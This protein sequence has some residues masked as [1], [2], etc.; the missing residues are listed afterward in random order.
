MLDKVEKVI[1]NDYGLLNYFDKKKC[2]IGSGLNVYN[3]YSV[4]HYG[5]PII[6]SHEMTRKQ[7][8]HLK[9]DHN[10]L[11]VPIYGKKELMVSEYCPISN[12]YFDEQKKHCQL[13]KKSQYQLMDRKGELLD[14][15]MDEYCRMHLLNAHTQL[16][17]KY[18]DIDA[19]TLLIQFTN[20]EPIDVKKILSF[21]FF[22]D[23][24]QIEGK[25]K[26]TFGYL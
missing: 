3:S 15:I 26:L 7:I 22:E 5:L 4:Q 9:C 21:Y 20:E 10:Q 24:S 11:I 23:S 2:I 14:L 18:D 6:L 19:H 1:V 12:Y 17:R 25:E 8:N 13:C 16:V